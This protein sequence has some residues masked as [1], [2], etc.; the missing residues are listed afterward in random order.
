VLRKRELSQAF[1]GFDP[2]V[3]ARF[4][5]ADQAALMPTRASSATA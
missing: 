4:T 1:A 5:E 3:V 2:A